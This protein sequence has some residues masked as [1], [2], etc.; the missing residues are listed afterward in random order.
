METASTPTSA[1]TGEYQHLLDAIQHNFTALLS[2][3]APLFTTDV[4]ELNAI[5]LV[6]FSSV[7]QRQYH[8]CHACRNFIERFGGL[9]TVDDQGHTVSA[10]WSLPEPDLLQCGE[11]IPA[12]E[13]MRKAVE[14]AKIT[15]VFLSSEKVW[16]TPVTGPWTH[17][18]AKPE[19]VYAGTA[20]SASQAMAE[21]RQ[22][23]INVTRALVEF[24]L[25]VVQQAVAVL[26]ADALTRSEK[27]L[28]AAEWLETLHED[29]SKAKQTNFRANITWK[30]VAGAP[31]GFCHPRSGMIGTLLEDIVAGL[32][33]EDVARRFSA[34]VHPLQY[35]R[36]QAA[37]SAGTIAQAEK[38]VE[39]LNIKAALRR[40]FARL[41]EVEKIWAPKENS[42][43]PTTGGVFS[44]LMPREAKTLPSQL[45][46]PAAVMTWVKFRD[47]VL[48]EATKI[49]LTVPHTGNFSALITAADPEAPLL[50]QWPNPVNWYVYVSG[51]SASRWGLTPNV[52]AEVTAITLQPSMW[53]GACCSHQGESVFL[54]LKGARDGQHRGLALFPETLR[55]EL[56]AVRSV[57]EAFSNTGKIEG[58]E[59][60]TACGLRLQKNN[61]WNTSLRVIDKS[62]AERCFILDRWD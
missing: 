52:E 28:G 62:G 35:Q 58:L 57:I 48:P 33:Y 22:D 34:K 11:Y 4:N 29:R 59:E 46:V 55:T 37:P 18:S 2:S 44:H 25:P 26:K 23:F 51:S 12:V 50:F 3:N 8:N 45:R 7:Q 19:K 53:S 43:A 39:K 32:A 49:K 15:G 27:F 13:T 38:L 41:E 24:P 1:S 36:P 9:V 56:H 42:P 60:A 40:R 16:G 17:F 54:L 5:Y 6:A 30:A 21:K 31:A 47:T 14:R 61:R 20:L 10:F